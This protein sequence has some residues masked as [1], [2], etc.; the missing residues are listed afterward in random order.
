MLA[1]AEDEETQRRG[2]VGMFYFSATLEFARD[3]QQRKA[4]LMD[5]IPLRQIGAHVC[6]NDRSLLALKAFLMLAIGKDRRARLRIHEGEFERI[7]RPLAA[8]LWIGATV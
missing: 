3:L 1:M 2:T 6:S 4:K 7:T 5:W 8:W